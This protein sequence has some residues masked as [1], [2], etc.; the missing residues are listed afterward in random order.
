[1]LRILAVS[2]CKGGVEIC[3]EETA[4][5]IFMREVAEGGREKTPICGFIFSACYFALGEITPHTTF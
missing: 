2:D 3:S 5:R 4:I 1:M